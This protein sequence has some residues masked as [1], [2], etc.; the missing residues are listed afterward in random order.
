MF[1]DTTWFD[2]V[3]FNQ[4]NVQMLFVVSVSEHI[5]GSLCGVNEILWYLPQ[6][7]TVEASLCSSLCHLESL[8]PHLLGHPAEAAQ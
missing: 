6:T 1:A 4:L 2:I 8:P 7:P 3:L 5:L